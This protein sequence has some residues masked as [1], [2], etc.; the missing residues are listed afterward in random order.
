MNKEKIIDLL[1][2]RSC[3]S[4]KHLVY[5]KDL[6]NSYCKFHAHYQRMIAASVSP[7]KD[8]ASKERI[9]SEI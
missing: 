8:W 6:Q 1:K 2:G 9:V 7:C 5:V 3:E 4:C